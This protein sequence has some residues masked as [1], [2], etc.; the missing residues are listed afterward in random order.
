M[1]AIGSRSYNPLE[2]KLQGVVAKVVVA[3]D[4]EKAGKGLV[5]HAHG[6]AAGYY[7]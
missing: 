5:A 1:L 7:I 3:G 6:F 2:E 4:A